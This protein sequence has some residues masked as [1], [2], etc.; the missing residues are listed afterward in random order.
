LI[1]QEK[2]I[3]QLKNFFKDIYKLGFIYDF[4]KELS[5]NSRALMNE[6]VYSD[7]ELKNLPYI[8]NDYFKIEKNGK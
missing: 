5:E 6:I 4:K 3:K 8:S 7:E 1:Q 2:E